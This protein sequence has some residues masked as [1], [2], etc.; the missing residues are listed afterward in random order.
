MAKIDIHEFDQQR[1]KLASGLSACAEQL[2]NTAQIVEDFAKML[3]GIDGS[4]QKD[5][6]EDGSKKRK[7][8][9]KP[10]D[11]N[12]PKRPASS[13]ILFQ[14]DIRTELKKQ[15]PNL[16]NPQLLSLISDKWK[17]MT[18]EEKETYNQEMLRLKQ[19]YSELKSAYD[20][21]SP[22]EVA[23]ANKAVADA[24]ATKKATK[25]PR[26]KKEAPAAVAATISPTAEPSSEEEESEAESDDEEVES[27]PV[28]KVKQQETSESEEETSDSDTEPAPAPKR[29]RAE[30]AHPKK[31][32]KKSK[33]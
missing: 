4:N 17:N 33:A 8:T 30:E 2:R 16:S 11:P 21:R 9:S 24:A 20:A 25:R 7:R 12:A 22:E 29:Q 14:N 27:K 26:V 10:K 18:D 13:Y 32:N 15:N 31:L 6:E 1:A 23:A 19:Q 3:E 28:S 5:V